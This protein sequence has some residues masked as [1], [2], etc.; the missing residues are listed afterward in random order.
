M[1][2]GRFIVPAITKNVMAVL[3]VIRRRRLETILFFVSILN[4]MIQ[5]GSTVAVFLA[6]PAI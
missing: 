3:M 2:K 5:S 1:R 6:F 4:E